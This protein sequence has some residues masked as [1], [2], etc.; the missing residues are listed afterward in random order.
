MEKVAEEM[1]KNDKKLK[2]EFELKLK[3]D[4]TFKKSPYQRL[5]YFYKKS[6]YWDKNLN[7]YPIMIIE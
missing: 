6:P 4:E 1:L 5:N 3:N 7:V 2:E